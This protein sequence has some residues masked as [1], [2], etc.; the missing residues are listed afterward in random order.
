[1]RFRLP[2]TCAAPLLAGARAK[3]APWEVEVKDASVRIAAHIVT[4]GPQDVWVFGGR[5]EKKREQ[6]WPTAWHWN[7]ESWS[8]ADLPGGQVGAVLAA[9]ASSA[10]D[11]WAV[12]HGGAVLH[13]DGA[14]W[15]IARRLSDMIA[16]DMDVFSPHDV[17]IYGTADPTVGSVIWSYTPSGWAKTA[18]P[19]AIFHTSARSARDIWALSFEDRLYHYDGL[20]WKIVPLDDVLPSAE[21]PLEGGY[22]LMQITAAANGIWITAEGFVIRPP[23]GDG[24]HDRWSGPPELDL[25]PLLLHGDPTGNR[26]TAESLVGKTERI[27]PFAA[28]I[29]DADGGVW[30]I[31]SVDLNA[32]ESALVHRA[33]TGTWTRAKIRTS[34]MGFFEVRAFAR[35]PGSTRFLAAGMHNRH[36]AILSTR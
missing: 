24:V 30:L 28:P 14:R 19:F 16:T 13:W 12:T 9:G 3:D 23:G 25:T 8:K 33:R 31:G 18:L 34:R 15:T 26:W 20:D 29:I 21:G 5:R 36:G 7:G 32:Y 17:Q 22:Q 1:M 11:V 35:I 2:K 6:L 4:A 10:S 27:D